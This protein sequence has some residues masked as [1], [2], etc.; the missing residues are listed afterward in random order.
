[1]KTIKLLLVAVAMLASTVLAT[2]CTAQFA[3]RPA[4]VVE[5]AP[6]VVTS[7]PPRVYYGGRWLHY[8]NHGYYY[9]TRGAWMPARAVPHH[10][11][12]YHRPGPVHVVRSAQP[13]H[14]HRAVRTR[15]Y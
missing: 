10:V 12:R 2:G 13:V 8:R 15:R 9:Y 14:V 11:V 1:M 3:A 4:V 5:P 6:V 7:P